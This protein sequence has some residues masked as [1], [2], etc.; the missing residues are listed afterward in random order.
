MNSTSS[1]EF[2][3]L[4]RGHVVETLH[5]QKTLWAS[6]KYLENWKYEGKVLSLENNVWHK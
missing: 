6:Q 2:E 5:T 4:W 1:G 3:V